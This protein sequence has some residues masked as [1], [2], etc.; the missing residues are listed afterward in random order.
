M[1]PNVR[2]DGAHQWDSSIFKNF[3]IR[4]AMRLE[5]RAEMFNFTNTVELR[6]ARADIRECA[7]RR[8]KLA[9]EF[10]AANP[11][12]FEVLLLI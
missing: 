9:A 12:R 11:I 6:A 10:A 8:G 5:F 4:E 7:I 3:P 1:L 2:A